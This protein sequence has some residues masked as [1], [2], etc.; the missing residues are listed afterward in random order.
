MY[1]L[2][3]ENNDIYIE[4]VLGRKHIDELDKS[5]LKSGDGWAHTK[6]LELLYQWCCKNNVPDVSFVEK[7]N[8]LYNIGNVKNYDF[9]IG[10]GDT[11]KIFK[12]NSLF[13]DMPSELNYIN[14][15]KLIFGEFEY[16]ITEP[17]FAKIFGK[18]DLGLSY[19]KKSYLQKPYYFARNE[20]FRKKSNITYIYDINSFYPFLLATGNMPIGK[21]MVVHNLSISDY[22]SM[23]REYEYQGIVS[24]NLAVPKNWIG[25]L[26]FKYR[27]GQQSASFWLQ[28]TLVKNYFVH[29]QE[30]SYLVDF[31]VEIQKINMGA[32]FKTVP[33]DDANVRYFYDLYTLRSFYPTLKVV[34]QKMI[35][36]LGRSDYRH[37]YK[38][39]PSN[40]D[41][42]SAQGWIHIGNNV[43][44]LEVCQRSTS[45]VNKLAYLHIVSEGRMLLTK[46]LLESADNLL[47]CDTDSI[48]VNKRNESCEDLMGNGLGNCKCEIGYDAN[49]YL[50]K[51]YT[52]FDDFGKKRFIWAGVGKEED[53]MRTEYAL[54][55]WNQEKDRYEAYSYKGLKNYFDHN[56]SKYSDSIFYQI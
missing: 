1:F 13:A 5:F 39:N 51:R 16:D 31:G 7:N 50:P 29:S 49:Y 11:S 4:D 36:R 22:M 41:I 38:I 12:F 55:N 35:G 8:L 48:H 42:L 54:R 18:L 20:I 45:R 26:P 6:D 52:Y 53:L 24:C 15:L 56:R 30:L 3:S 28:D 46:L 10:C 14:F 27:K 44:R 2:R 40:I 21:S 33:M 43:W 23:T 47:Y 34:M 25:L 19:L 32:F 17:L 9:F 37:I